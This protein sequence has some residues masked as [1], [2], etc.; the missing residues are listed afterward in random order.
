MGRISVVAV[1]GAVLGGGVNA[2]K[3]CFKYVK[4]IFK[5]DIQTECE[6]YQQR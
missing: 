3:C 4:E 1:L 6:V 5:L 2:A